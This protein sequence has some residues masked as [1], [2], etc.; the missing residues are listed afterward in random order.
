MANPATAIF[1]QIKYK[2]ESVYGT[3]PSPLTGSKAIRRI[4]FSPD[5]SKEVYQSSELRTDQQVADFRHGARRAGGTLKGELSPKAYEDFFAALL[6]KTFAATTAVS[7]LSASLAVNGAHPNYRITATGFLTG[8]KMKIGDVIRITAGTWTAGNLNVNLVVTAITATTLDVIPLNGKTLTAEGPITGSTLTIVGKKTMVPLTS[9]TDVSF[10]FES[11][12]AD[13]VKSEMYTG[14]KVT[15][16]ALALPSTGMSTVDFTFSGKD[17]E[18]NSSEQMTSPTA[19][20]A[21]GVAAAVNGLL[22]VGAAQQTVVRDLSININ[23]NFGGSP[24]VGANTVPF[25][26]PGRVTVD[27]QFTAFFESTTLR[28]AFLAESEL[29][30]TVVLSADNTDAADFVGI[31]L[32]RIKLGSASKNDAQDGIVQTFSFTALLKATGGSN[33]AYDA[34]TIAIQDSQAT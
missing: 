20:P 2:A 29:G 24:V 16:A 13:L 5:L 10:T 22:V 23:G 18:T 3:K 7:G 34:T 26:F 9:H 8:D 19:A 14:M 4:E 21:Y 12:F 28:D 6:R 11:W 1:R 15:Q 17:I 32:P 30:L 25:Q 33:T 27:G 31:N